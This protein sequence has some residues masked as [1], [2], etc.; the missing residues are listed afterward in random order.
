MRAATSPAMTFWAPVELSVAAVQLAAA[1]RLVAADLQALVGPGGRAEQR[2]LTAARAAVAARV[3]ALAERPQAVELLET[4]AAQPR[5]EAQVPAA[6]AAEDRATMGAALAA[7]RLLAERPLAVA[8]ARLA[9]RL[10][11]SRCS[12]L[13]P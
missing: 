2:E 7:R 13:Q 3:M 5:A 11:A 12:C 9:A 4:A 10:K 6:L 1:V 8:L